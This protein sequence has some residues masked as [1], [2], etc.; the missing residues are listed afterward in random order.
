MLILTLKILLLGLTLSASSVC[1]WFSTP[2]G[3][4]KALYR[5]IVKKSSLFDSPQILRALGIG[6]FLY[7][8]I[9][10]FW[11]ISK[12]LLELGVFR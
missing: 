10:G 7:G 11:S 12:T 8:L 5:R 3:Y 1:L 2:W 6:G 9:Y 4:K